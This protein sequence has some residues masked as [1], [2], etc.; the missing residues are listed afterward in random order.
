MS[1]SLIPR[2]AS[3]A[4]R[5]CEPSS[6]VESYFYTGGL[7]A[8]FRWLWSAPPMLTLHLLC[9]SALPQ[10]THTTSKLSL[11]RRDLGAATAHGLSFFA[12]GC[13]TTGTGIATQ[14]ICDDA[15]DV[16]D[17]VSPN[18]T[19][20][21]VRATLT[22]A[23]GWAAGCSSGDLIVFAGGGR[24]GTEPHSR[25]ADVMNATTLETVGHPDALSEGR[26]GIGCAAVDG[27]IYFTG[28]KVTINGY[29]DVYMSRMVDMFSSADKSWSLAPFNL[30]GG[31][32]STV[33][34][35][36]PPKSEGGQTALVV[37]GGWHKQQTY[38]PES[39]IDFFLQPL[40]TGGGLVPG[41]QL[42]AP[43]YDVG[44][45]VGADGHVYL[46]GDK[47][48]TVLSP[49]GE[50]VRNSALP[51][52][53]VGQRASPAGG[54]AVP[55]SRLPHNGARVGRRVCFYGASPS[56]LFCHDT[57]TGQW[58]KG[59]ACA[60]EHTGGSMTAPGGGVILVAGGYDQRSPVFAT[61]PV[62]DIFR[63]EE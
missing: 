25:T 59:L 18:G 14:F 31:R 60:A 8:E 22:E 63:F 15:S 33:A 48:L 55:R 45:A 36:V 47:Y 58:E 44:A 2:R 49:N 61:T 12:G 16:I 52:A 62:I 42:A 11:P 6:Q 27:N 56:T 43:A 3:G 9:G 23:R 4:S 17:V 39:A 28:G 50:L 41:L 46:V 10:P 53:M 24:K 13:T 38:G 30:T 26:W 57:S 34:L 21:A 20:L 5:V 40:A 54:G 37:A 7:R 1:A 29:Q 19:L 51:A 32:E 35:A